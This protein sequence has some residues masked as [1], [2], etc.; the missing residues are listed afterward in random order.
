[1]TLYLGLY[2]R[3]QQGHELVYYNN[4]IAEPDIWREM[5]RLENLSPPQIMQ[6]REHRLVSTDGQRRIVWSWYRV[7]G[8][9]TTSRY[10]V[11]LLQVAGLLTGTTRAAVVAVA[12][13]GGDDV[14]AARRRLGDFVTIMNSQLMDLADGRSK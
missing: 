3:Q 12:T 10:M 11:K 5:V 4:R 8:R 6:V 13:D 2:A 9:T 7:A 14:E 1:M